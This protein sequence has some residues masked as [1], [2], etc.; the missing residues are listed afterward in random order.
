ME[1]FIITLQRC[2]DDGDDRM[3]TDLVEL[4]DRQ[5]RQIVCDFPGKTVEGW[6]GRTVV[7]L[8]REQAAKTPDLSLI[9][10]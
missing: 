10:I 6:G 1:Q 8:F 3:L 2:C 5:R 9:H 4:P 7:S